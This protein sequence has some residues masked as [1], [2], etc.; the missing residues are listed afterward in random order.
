LLLGT[1]TFGKGSVQTVINI[2]EQ[3]AVKL[4]TARYYTP[5]GRSIQAE[6]ITPDV[7]VNYREFKEPE[8]GYQ[9]I[10]ENDL[11]GRLENDSKGQKS[12]AK[13]A[14]KSDEIKDLLAKDYQL[15][16]AFNLLNGLILYNQN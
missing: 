7:I 11:P 3:E 2:G 16:E 1:D 4:T 15:N 5:S 13:K 12:T 9:R 10:K 6:G 14:A 8:K